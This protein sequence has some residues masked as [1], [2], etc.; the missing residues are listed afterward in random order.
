MTRRSTTCSRP[1]GGAAG[2]RMRCH[3]RR[4]PRRRRGPPQ[5]PVNS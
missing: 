4:T 1:Y 3:R 5:L 2:D